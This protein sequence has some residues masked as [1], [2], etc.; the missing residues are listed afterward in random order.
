MKFFC[1]LFGLVQIRVSHAN[2]IY[3]VHLSVCNVSETLG[4]MERNSS[5]RIFLINCSVLVL[6]MPLAVFLRGVNEKGAE[7]LGHGGNLV[8]P[9]P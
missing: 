7:F 1:A 8:M 4:K 6:E 5:I 9:F 3:V 2:V